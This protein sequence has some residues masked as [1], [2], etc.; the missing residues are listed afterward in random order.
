MVEKFV[1]K[2]LDALKRQYDCSLA[3][4]DYSG[5]LVDLLSSEYCVQFHDNPFCRLYDQS[6]LNFYRNCVVSDNV[7][8]RFKSG[9]TTALRKI[10]WA[11]ALELVFPIRKFNQ[12]V[13]VI[14]IGP[15]RPVS[16][17]GT[18]GISIRA[19]E[20][21]R[22]EMEDHLAL[23]PEITREKLDTVELFGELVVRELG[24]ELEEAPQSVCGRTTRE[25]RIRRFF[26][27]N[28]RSAVRVDDLARELRLGRTRTEQVLR[29]KYDM[30]FAALLN[31]HRIDAAANRLHNTDLTIGEIAEF[32]G[33][34]SV[35]YFHRVFLRVIGMTPESF[36]RSRRRVDLLKA[37]YR[38]KTLP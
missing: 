28:F 21:L 5:E 29:E 27:H 14:F 2:A 12:L 10:C 6:E 24:R 15:F 3:F 32:V 1:R 23:L 7:Q 34:R 36:R 11:G 25:E 31:M 8:W 35:N 9:R 4:Q 13:G 19:A 16:P 17:D 38:R 30:T 37:V 22:E 33:Y 20:I 18:W 26:D